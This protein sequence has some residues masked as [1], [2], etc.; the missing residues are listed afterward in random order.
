MRL[1]RTQCKKKIMKLQN[2]N[3]KQ[4]NQLRK[5]IT[6]NLMLKWNFLKLKE[7]KI[8]LL[9]QLEEKLNLFTFE[10]EQFITLWATLKPYLW[11]KGFSSF[12]CLTKWPHKMK[13]SI[14]HTE[15]RMRALLK[16]WITKSRT[17]WSKSQNSLKIRISRFKQSSPL[18]QEDPIHWWLKVIF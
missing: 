10:L 1:S 15:P 2:F 8:K 11:M 17:V 6:L 12:T 4:L 18:L 7:H 16:T 9:L 5:R 13:I 3:L 14:S